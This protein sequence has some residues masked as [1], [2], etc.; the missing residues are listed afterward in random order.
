MTGI[1]RTLNKFT[2]D[3]KLSG[4]TDMPEER[5][6]ET[7][8]GLRGGLCQPHEVQQGQVQGPAS[9]SGQSQT[10]IWTG[11]LRAALSRRIWEGFDER[12][13]IS[14]Q[15]EPAV[16][17]ANHI[18]CCNK[19]TVTSGLR[20]LILSY[21]TLVR[22]RL[23]YCVQFWSSQNKKDMELLEWIQRRITKMISWLEQLPYDDRLS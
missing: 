19:R 20:K 21:S 23:L 11:C 10:Q 22:P 18:L 14:Q 2:D 9:K 5:D 13:N 12:F 4:A 7:W 1:E 3:T 15:C 8:T 6:S 16:R 17:K